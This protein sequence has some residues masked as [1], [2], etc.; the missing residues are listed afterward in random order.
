MHNL[1]C[2]ADSLK[3]EGC[4]MI[5]APLF[6]SV[7]IRKLAS[8]DHLKGQHLTFDVLSSTFGSCYVGLASVQLSLKG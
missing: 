2:L 4:Y 1:D 6:K 5:S 8:S 7:L 3:T